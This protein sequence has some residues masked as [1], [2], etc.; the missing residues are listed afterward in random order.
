[1]KNLQKKNYKNLTSQQHQK[2]CEE[3]FS[4]LHEKIVC[5]KFPVYTVNTIFSVFADWRIKPKAQSCQPK[6]PEKFS[7]FCAEC[8]ISKNAN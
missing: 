1:M 6:Y 7:G 8:E 2:I 4:V 3:I 5:V